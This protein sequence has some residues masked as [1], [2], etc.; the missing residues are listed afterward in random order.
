MLNSL[1]E[2]RNVSLTLMVH[3]HYILFSNENVVSYQE[4]CGTKSQTED[5]GPS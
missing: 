5:H 1:E 2:S 4:K 3:L